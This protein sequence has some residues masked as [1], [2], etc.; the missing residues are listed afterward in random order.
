MIFRCTRPSPTDILLL[1]ELV[2][3]RNGS[4]T[5]ARAH[6]EEAGPLFVPIRD[7]ESGFPANPLGWQ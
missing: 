6:P 5:A 2:R 4:D 7:P 1:D 3:D